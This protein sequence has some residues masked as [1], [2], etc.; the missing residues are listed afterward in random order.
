MIIKY[1]K[2]VLSLI[3]VLFLFYFRYATGASRDCAAT[4][5]K[6]KRKIVKLWVSVRKFKWN[7]ICWNPSNWAI[8][9]VLQYSTSFS[10]KSAYKMN[11]RRSSAAKSISCEINLFQ[12]LMCP[13]S[14]L[15]NLDDVNISWG[16]NFCRFVEKISEFIRWHGAMIRKLAE[17]HETLKLW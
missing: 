9:K 3:I 7:W 12:F 17:F 16:W 13:L 4:C 2:N 10:P 11:R 14:K 6:I 15:S 1:F 5:V 8:Q